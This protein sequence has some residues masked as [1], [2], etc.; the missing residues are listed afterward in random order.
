MI[1][2]IESSPRDEVFAFRFLNL[3]TSI[4]FLQ[5]KVAT[6]LATDWMTAGAP[7]R[8]IGGN[9]TNFASQQSPPHCLEDGL[10]ASGASLA[11]HGPS[12]VMR[13]MARRRSR[14]L[15][16]SDLLTDRFLRN[17]DGSGNLAAGSCSLDGTI[18]SMG[19]GFAKVRGAGCG[20][21]CLGA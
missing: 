12:T 14:W 10:S 20:G 2:D 13:M 11:R 21:G 1:R 19:G 7:S 6:Q 8:V 4:D 17:S 18:I 15:R 9:L 3:V 16:K 5:G